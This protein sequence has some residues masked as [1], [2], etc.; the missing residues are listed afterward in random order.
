MYHIRITTNPITISNSVPCL[1]AKAGLSSSTIVYTQ[2]ITYL[3]HPCQ[4]E[5]QSPRWFAEVLLHNTLSYLHRYQFPLQTL[6]HTLIPYQPPSPTLIDT[7]D[8]GVIYGPSSSQK[9]LG[10]LLYDLTNCTS[11]AWRAYFCSG[12]SLR[13]TTILTVNGQT[14]SSDRSYILFRLGQVAIEQHQLTSNLFWIV[15]PQNS[16]RLA[17]W[18][19]PSLDDR[20][21]WKLSGNL[22]NPHS[23]F[24]YLEQI[25]LAGVI[26]IAH[27]W[28]RALQADETS[29]SVG[30]RTLL[31]AISKPKVW[32][33]QV[34]VIQ[35]PPL[36]VTIVP[37]TVSLATTLY[38]YGSPPTSSVF[39]LLS[40]H[41]L[42]SSGDPSS[43]TGCLNELAHSSNGGSAD[44]EASA[45]RCRS[46]FCHG[47][48]HGN[49]NRVFVA[50][51]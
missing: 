14:A 4:R 19:L 30:V 46:P 13:S 37:I 48:S 3:R 41:V 10:S 36:K 32:T 9:P 20:G 17:R 11:I 7:S 44:Y 26:Q 5:R 27:Y 35:W 51:P 18:A 40:S 16:I 38:L 6:R 15:Q 29:K 8:A 34:R 31:I 45:P 47:K 22:P 1:A 42:V 12:R 25:R 2:T 49:V 50:I 33:L 23:L 39:R 21:I 28:N 43:P 24:I